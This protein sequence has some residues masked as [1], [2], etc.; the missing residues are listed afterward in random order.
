MRYFLAF[1][2]LKERFKTH[3][4]LKD[5][6]KDF[7]SCGIIEEDYKPCLRFLRDRGLLCYFEAL[8]DQA[9]IIVLDPQWLLDALTC[10]IYDSKWHNK[11][12][13]PTTKSELL[14]AYKQ[15][16]FL[17]K[18]N[19]VMKWD[20]YKENEKLFFLRLMQDMFLL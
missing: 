11:S 18:A 19:L 6:F 4:S 8:N 7:N 16:A 17:S 10:V 14:E 2:R 12:E 20:K 3:T 15:E 9:D 1:E 13:K 5:C